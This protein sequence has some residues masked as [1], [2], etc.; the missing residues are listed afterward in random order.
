MSGDGA[1][2]Q[3]A[4]V[5]VLEKPKLQARSHAATGNENL[6]EL[7]NLDNVSLKMIR[8]GNKKNG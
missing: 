3:L 5:A 4:L 2:L 1:R 8:R 7:W 6:A